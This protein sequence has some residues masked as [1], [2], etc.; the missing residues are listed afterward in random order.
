MFNKYLKY[1]HKYINLKHNGGG[2]LD[3]TTINTTIYTN[4]ITISKDIITGDIDV[5]RIDIVEWSDENTMT[6]IV[7]P[8]ETATTIA[9]GRKRPFVLCPINYEELKRVSN[10]ARFNICVFREDKVIGIVVVNFKED[11]YW[12]DIICA[13]SRSGAGSYLISLVKKL[14]IGYP[15]ELEGVS[16]A[17]DFYKAQGFK[18]I[19]DLSNGHKLMRYD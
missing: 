18:I 2:K 16:S 6:N 9:W 19:R 5:S 15:I 17:V 12:I 14:T 7:F 8:G 11:K 13:Q 10:T 1:K 4:G 3:E